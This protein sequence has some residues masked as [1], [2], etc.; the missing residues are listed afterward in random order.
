[1]MLPMMHKAKTPA[2]MAQDLKVIEADPDIPPNETIYI[3]NINDRVKLSVLKAYLEQ[4]FNQFGT[5]R[6]I[7]AMGSFWRR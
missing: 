7:V 2:K 4:I 6:Q 1:M 3:K 5:I